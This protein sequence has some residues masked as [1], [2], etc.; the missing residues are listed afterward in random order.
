MK[1]P[2]IGKGNF[3][4]TV[5][6][7]IRESTALTIQRGESLHSNYETHISDGLCT[8]ITHEY[9]ANTYGEVV[10]PEHAELIIELVKV[11][12]FKVWSM[13]DID[14]I[15]SFIFKGGELCL[16]KC[17]LHEIDVKGLDKIT[18]PLPPKQ[19]QTATP[20]EDF[21]MQQIMKNAGD[22]LVLGCEDSKCDE[23]PKVGDEVYV[24]SKVMENN[25][26]LEAA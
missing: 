17:K 13:N 2:Y 12:G 4:G 23:W 1:Y 20:E 8:N 16:L 22:N 9:L 25:S 24:T 19:I 14:N 3:D 11:N 10:S 18:I 21:E 26:M 6:L 5:F 7:F 15:F